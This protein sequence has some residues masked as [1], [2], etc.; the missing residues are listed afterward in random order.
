MAGAIAALS[1]CS[2]GSKLVG[3][4]GG[5]GSVVPL[6]WRRL[7]GELWWRKGADS[8]EHHGFDVF[9]RL[10]VSALAGQERLIGRT[11]RCRSFLM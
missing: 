6:G 8:E 5:N 7:W 10:A 3:A 2:E 11:W 1:R 9:A 4:M